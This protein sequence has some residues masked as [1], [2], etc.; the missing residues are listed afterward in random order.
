MSM[1]KSLCF[2]MI[3]LLTASSLF[4]ACKPDHQ[5]DVNLE[6]LEFELTDVNTIET[7]IL[8]TDESTTKEIDVTSTDT[9]E[10]ITEIDPETQPETG[11]ETE[12]EIEI[13]DSELAYSEGLLFETIMEGYCALVGFGDCADEIIVIPPVSPNGE[14]VAVIDIKGASSEHITG[15]VI[16]E[17][18]LSIQRFPKCKSLTS[19]RV[20]KDNL[21]YHSK[22]NCL[23]ITSTNA[24]VAGC[25]TSIIPDYVTRLD[26]SAFGYCE[27]L[28]DITIP[29]NV[30]H[31]DDYTFAHC[32]GLTKITM[33]D[34]VTT[35]RPWAFDGC[36]GLTDVKISNGVTIIGGYTFRD[37]T[38]L[39]SVVIPKGVTMIGVEAFNGCKSLTDVYFTG[40]EQE[41]AAISIEEGNDVL[42]TATIHYNYV[43]EM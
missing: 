2:L 32:T 20:N 17:S 39:E 10:N 36:S 14:S 35:L 22:D 18:V 29:D 34:S 37:C 41:W 12:A 3:L 38:S 16:P 15:I 11:T 5:F 24:L 40:T 27:N 26:Y 28:T 25:Q 42:A 8:D 30:T 43:P 1:K 19:I 33:P 31:I 9:S 6:T 21:A 7:S 13:D 4:V 23:I